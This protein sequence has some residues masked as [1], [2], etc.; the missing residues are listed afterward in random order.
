MML[1]LASTATALE[2]ESNDIAH[3]LNGATIPVM[4]RLVPANNTVW[5]GAAMPEAKRQIC[6]LSSSLNQLMLEPVLY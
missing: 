1:V 2:R 4:M 6:L 3:C 5:T